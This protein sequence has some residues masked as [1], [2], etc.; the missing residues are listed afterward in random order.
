MNPALEAQ[1]VGRVHRLGQK[2]EVEIIQ[3]VVKDS[4]KEW[5]ASLI[6]KKYGAA[7]ANPIDAAAKA[8]PVGSLATDKSVLLAQEFDYLLGVSKETEAAEAVSAPTAAMAAASAATVPPAIV[9]T[10]SVR[11]SKRNDNNQDDPDVDGMEV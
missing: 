4:V 11:R 5:L 8:A 9:K 7:S 2:R 6:R 3:L 1:A 10:E